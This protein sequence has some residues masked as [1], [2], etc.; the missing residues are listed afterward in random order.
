MIFNLKFIKSFLPVAQ[1]Y[2]L[3]DKYLSYLIF[4][5]LNENDKKNIKKTVRIY[6]NGTQWSRI[7]KTQTPNG[8][9]IWNNTFFKTYGKA[10]IHLGINDIEKF[11]FYNNDSLNNWWIHTEPPSYINLF[12]FN[13]VK[14]SNKFKKIFTCSKELINLNFPFIASAPYVFWYI[15]YSAYH[16]K[17]NFDY[18]NYNY[19]VNL[20]P[21]SKKNKIVLIAS[22]VNDINGHLER[23]NFIEK[24]LNY[25]FPIELW[26]SSKWNNFYQYKGFAINKYEVYKNAKYV[27]VIENEKENH[28][29][30]E[31]FADA[32]LSFCIPIYY[33]CKNLSQYFPIGSYFEIDIKDEN[34]YSIISNLINSKYYEDNFNNLILA[35]NLILSKHNFFSFIDE[36]INKEI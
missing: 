23:S 2:N 10:D 17:S 12:H 20:N 11:N 24:I 14:N 29:W 1:F 9:G 26:G 18:I 6:D 13:S 5:N 22:A 36:E 7:I 34:I 16:I 25:N 15:G 32:I 4:L 30:S 28:Y 8:S 3:Y 19:L 35:R 33:G 27:L 31:K 21:E